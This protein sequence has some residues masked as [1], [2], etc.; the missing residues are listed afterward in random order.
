MCR[1]VSELRCYLKEKGAE[2][3]EENAPDGLLRDITQVIEASTIC[4]KDSTTEPGQPQNSLEET[5]YKN[6]LMID[7][8]IVI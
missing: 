6:Y 7:L 2:I 3:S 5:N 1:Q 4:L 8:V